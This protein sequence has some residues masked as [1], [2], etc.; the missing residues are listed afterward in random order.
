[1][2]RLWIVLPVLLVAGVASS[3]AL[4]KPASQASLN[5]FQ[6]C[7]NWCIAH[8]KTDV[9]YRKCYNQCNNYWL[10]QGHRS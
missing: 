4:S 3:L 1:M 8:N 7:V 9:S 6:K 5:G 2:T 10:I